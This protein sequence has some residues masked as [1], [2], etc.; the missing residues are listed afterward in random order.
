MKKITNKHLV[1]AVTLALCSSLYVGTVDV[2]AATSVAKTIT[3]TENV[4]GADGS[5]G[6]AGG[7]D[8]N[9]SGITDATAPGTEQIYVTTVTVTGTG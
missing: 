9:A 3:I 1:A 7:Q 2:Y 6:S 4:K 5:S 8:A